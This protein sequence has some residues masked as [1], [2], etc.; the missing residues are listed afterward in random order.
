LKISKGVYE[1]FLPD[2]FSVHLVLCTWLW[3]HLADGKLELKHQICIWSLSLGLAR[4]GFD[5][6]ACVKEL[7]KNVG[8]L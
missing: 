7:A 5:S 4:T 6:A 2:V 8:A 1:V 3:E